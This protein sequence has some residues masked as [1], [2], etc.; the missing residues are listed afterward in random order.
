GFKNKKIFPV[1]FDATYYYKT[2]C[3][4]HCSFRLQFEEINSAVQGYVLNSWYNHWSSILIEHLFWTHHDILPAIGQ[5]K[6]VDFFLHGI[7]FDLKVT[8]LPEGY[9]KAKR[10]ERKWPQ[11]VVLL[12]QE[13][14]RLG[15]SF[16][17]AERDSSIYYEITEKM[18]DKNSSQCLAVLNLLHEQRQQILNKAK[19]NPKELAK[20]L[21]ENQGEMR[22]SAE[23]RLFL[24]LVDSV[25]YEQSWKLKRNIDNLKPAINDYLNHFD[26]NNINRFE[27]NFQ[28]KTQ[29]YTVLSDVIFVEK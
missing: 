7:P 23:N 1:F 11:E 27:L 18:R 21:Y 26:K 13:A 10:K 25:N 9:I 5:I 20:W 6:N 19:S 24:V 14:K 3:N 29:S 4:V 28:Y 22:F 8:Y 17:K 16:N 12:K 15:I 2:C